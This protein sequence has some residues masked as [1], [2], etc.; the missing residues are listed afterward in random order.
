MWGKSVNEDGCGEEEK[1]RK[2]EAGVGGHHK[3]GLEDEGTVGRGD[4]K[5]GCVEATCQ[6]HRST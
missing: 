4:V 3:R 2:T 6:I 1:E 5:P